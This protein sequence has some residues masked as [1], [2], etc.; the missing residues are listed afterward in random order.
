M[1]KRSPPAAITD[2]LKAAIAGSGVSHLALSEATGVER[3]SIGRFIRGERSIRLDKA[4]KL[5]AY[6]GLELRARATRNE[7]T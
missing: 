5:A 1:T 6:F 4:D 3:M 2:V 7:D